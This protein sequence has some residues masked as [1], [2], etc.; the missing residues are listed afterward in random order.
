[1]SRGVKSSIGSGGLDWTVRPGSS[2]LLVI[3]MQNDFVREGGVME[4]PLARKCLPNIRRLVDA[5]R[6]SGIPVVFTRHV[7]YDAFDVSPLEVALQPRLRKEGMREGSRGAQVVEELQPRPDE[8]VVSKHRYDAF[9]NTDLET[10][11]R[12]AWGLNAVDTLIITG[13]VT[14]ICCESTA[15]SAFMR[16][17]KVVFASDANGGLDEPS[18]A[19]TLESISRAFGRVASTREILQ[20]I[21]SCI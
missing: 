20:E 14:N 13:T 21:E 19:A 2:A 10:I 17:F 4:V 12:T 18:H 9:Y 8:F 7:L 5:A 15:R 16:D 6:D 11:L 1:M 3:D